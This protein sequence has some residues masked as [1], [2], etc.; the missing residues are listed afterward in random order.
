MRA[1]RRQTIFL[2]SRGW[3]CAGVEGGGEG[4]RASGIDLGD[5]G[6]VEYR[7]RGAL[8]ALNWLFYGG[9]E[10]RWT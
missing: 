6:M 3:A 2:A 4:L 1:R 5:E 9:K 8:G 10:I 7:R